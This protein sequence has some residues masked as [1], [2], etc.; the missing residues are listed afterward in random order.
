MQGRI[1]NEDEMQYPHTASPAY[2]P[3]V[4]VTKRNKQPGLQHR[5]DA[6]PDLHTAS[7]A[8]WLAVAASQCYAVAAMH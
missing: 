7:G 3:A 8:G 4:A 2:Q 6:L 1:Y 5:R